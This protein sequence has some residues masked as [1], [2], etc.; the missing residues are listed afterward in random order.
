MEKL[1]NIDEARKN[2]IVAASIEKQMPCVL[3]RR[4]TQGWC[5]SKS[6]FLASPDTVGRLFLSAASGTGLHGCAPLV[7]GERVG[8]TFRRGHK[9][10]MCATIVLDSNTDV[11]NGDGERVPC[12]ELQWP[13]ALQELQ[14]RVYHR[15]TPPGRRIHVRFWPGGVAG[16]TAA[17]SLE[18]GIC[19]GVM[20]DLSAGGISILAVDVAPDTF[21]VGDTL[22][23][24][25]C[26]KPRGETLV[27]DATFRHL[28]RQADGSMAVG[29]Q[30]VGLETTDHGRHMLSCLAG[31]VTEYQRGHARQQRT[32]LAGNF[33]SS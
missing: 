15:A 27:L 19:S 14:R 2:D 12:V 17:E 32:K 24:A 9:K 11:A 6:H 8:L 16:R 30:F 23:C 18:Q 3:T 7:P 13:E 25:F 20:L 29:L 22:G 5:P 33:A 1:I 26:P 28:D 21:V 31:I 10:C 4:T